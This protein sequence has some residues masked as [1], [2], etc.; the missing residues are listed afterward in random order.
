MKTYV[1]KG[2]Q[3]CAVEYIVTSK[4][5]PDDFKT[6]EEFFDQK[7]S[8]EFDKI[9]YCSKPEFEECEEYNDE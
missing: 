7:I 6:L 8:V 5:S 9:T 3:T 2:I 4:K 1:L